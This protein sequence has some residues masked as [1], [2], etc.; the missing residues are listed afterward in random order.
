MSLPEWVREYKTDTKT[1][2]FKRGDLI[3]PVNE[4]IDIIQA[5]G[6][7]LGELV[8]LKDDV[9]HTDPEGYERR[10]PLAWQAARDALRLYQHGSEVGGE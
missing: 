5:L 6:E 1:P 10:K 7:S 4:M 3:L 8:T 2:E 9:K